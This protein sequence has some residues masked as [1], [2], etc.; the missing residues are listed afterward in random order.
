MRDHV[1]VGRVDERDNEWDDGIAT[2]VFGVGKDD[3][4]GRSECE[5]CPS[6]SVVFRLS[7]ASR[8][9]N[10]LNTHDR[11]AARLTNITSNILI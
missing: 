1:E 7:R 8:N 6:A 5:F 9:P 3:E 4:L 11:M 2:V 10:G